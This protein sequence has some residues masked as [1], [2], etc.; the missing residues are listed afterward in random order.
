MNWRVLRFGEVSSTQ[1]VA[2][3]H[4]VPDGREWLVVVAETQSAGRGS[5]G[6]EWESR[7]G[8]LYM[9]VAVKPEGHQGLVPLL[10]GV[11][12]SEA[13]TEVAGVETQLKWPN[14][15]LLHGKKVGGILSES[16]WSGGALRFILLG[17][18]VNVNN[19]LPDTLP[20]AT[21]LS[22]ELGREV[23]L[24]QLMHSIL[25]RIE[26]NF[27]KLHLDPELVLC[28]WKERGQ[29]LGRH[30]VVTDRSGE[31]I[32]GMATDVD[33]EGALLVETDHGLRKVLS[34]RI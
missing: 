8:G 18:G 24:D 13:I 29:T 14:D 15:V 27:D 33:R 6:R 28:S 10:A 34:G 17:V 1:E 11:V 32:E 31:V 4:A 23:D 5:R 30:V 3:E 19:V 7:S 12:V 21:S 26:R 22:K 16:E 20:A 9:T 25:R 2:R